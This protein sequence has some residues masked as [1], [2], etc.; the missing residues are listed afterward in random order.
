L[1]KIKTF[2]E[3]GREGAVAEWRWSGERKRVAKR[4]GE[5]EKR[6]QG[7]GFLEEEEKKGKKEKT[8]SSS[9]L[10]FFS[11]EIFLPFSAPPT[12]PSALSLAPIPI[13]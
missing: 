13:R 2:G 8:F 12:T 5:E 11:T 10:S 4:R 9:S 1:K 3:G 7:R 6:Q